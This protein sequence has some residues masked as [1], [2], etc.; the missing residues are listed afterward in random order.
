MWVEGRGKRENLKGC[1]SIW[2]AVVIAY[3]CHDCVRDC[4]FVVWFYLFYLLLHYCGL[5]A[6]GLQIFFKIFFNNK[7]EISALFQATVQDKVKF[8]NIKKKN[9]M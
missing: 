1:L 3:L 8:L 6:A 9:F 4:Y 2:L 5:Q 7:A